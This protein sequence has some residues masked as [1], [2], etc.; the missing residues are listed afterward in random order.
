MWLFFCYTIQLITIKLCAKF[1]NP[2]PSSCWEIFDE[3]KVYGQTDRQTNII[4][5]KAKTIYPLYTSYR[6]YNNTGAQMLDPI[7]H[8]TLKLIKNCKFWRENIKILP[9]FTQRYGRYYIMLQNW[10]YC[11]YG[12]I[13]LPDAM[14][15]DKRKWQKVIFTF[16][17]LIFFVFI[18][19]SSESTKNFV[20][21][22]VDGIYSTSINLCTS[23]QCCTGNLQ[24]SV[25]RK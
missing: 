3:K 25:L 14:P 13:S 2:N 12:V 8:M 23:I 21:L 7:Y 20:C 24:K 5:E 10:F 1:Q 16:F 4:T 18:W 15:C 11:M 17:I 6:G 22:C 9:S 19:T